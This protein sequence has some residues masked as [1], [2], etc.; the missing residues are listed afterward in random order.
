MAFNSYLPEYVEQNKS[1]L[2]AKSVFGAPSIDNMTIQT[3]LKGKTSINL[4]DVEVALQDGSGCGFEATNTKLSQ[5]YI[6]PMHYKV[7]KAW[8][9]KTLLNTY[10]QYQVVSAATGKKLP[11]EAEIMNG[12]TDGVKAEIEKTIWVGYQGTTIG[13]PGEGL[14]TIVLDSASGVNKVTGY[15]GAN[16]WAKV[17]ETYKALPVEVLGHDDLTGY[18]SPAL[19]EALVL[20]LVNAN[21]YHFNVNDK[22]GEITMPGTM[23]KIVRCPGMTNSGVDLMF[24]RKS[25]VFYGVDLESDSTDIDL[26]Y[27]QDNREFRATVEF[28]AGVNVAYPTEIAILT[29]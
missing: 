6:N 15:T 2:I 27:S 25:N 10:A 18:A 23:V 19:F 14:A 11:F 24:A 16:S 21:L 8:C 1:E 29:A 9:D 4:I 13:D 12:L 17:Q 5:R 26:W 20:E 28:V 3:G 7:D 22:A